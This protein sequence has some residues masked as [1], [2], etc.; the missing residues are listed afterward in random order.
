M[1]VAQELDIDYVGSGN[2]VF[3]GKAMDA[4]RFYLDQPD[5]P[6]GWYRPDVVSDVLR[7]FEGDPGA[8]E[9]YL[10]VYE[11]PQGSRRYCLGVDVV[12]GVADGDY[13][14]IVVYDRVTKSVSAAYWSKL[15]EV[16]L[17]KVV[18]MVSRHYGDPWVGIETTGP[19]L[20]TFDLCVELGMANLFM[21]PRFDVIN[22]G[23]T[24]KKGWRTD[25]NSRN[26]LVSG[27]REWL[28]GRTGRPRSHRLIGECMS[29]VRGR[30]GKPQAKAGTHDDMVM[31]FGIAIQ[32]DGI[33]PIDLEEVR[34]YQ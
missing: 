25:A 9:G 33:V 31:A 20:A 16:L 12:E 18:W 4:L 15:D 2:P 10:V 27:I 29:F 28:I 3:D 8:W 17:S 30:T 6:V 11:E 19:G 26:E 14:V 1:E 34:E 24:Y 32:V 23:V 21:A 22:G 7:R 5:E 13:A